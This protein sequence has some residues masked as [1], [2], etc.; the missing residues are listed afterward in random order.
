MSNFR[1]RGFSGK[2]SRFEISG[3]RGKFII[4]F[5]LKIFEEI[6]LANEKVGLQSSYLTKLFGKNPVIWRKVNKERCEFVVKDF[7]ELH[8]FQLAIAITLVNYDQ[9]KMNQIRVLGRITKNLKSFLL[10]EV[11]KSPD[12]ISLHELINIFTVKIKAKNQEKYIRP[13][14]KCA[15][16]EKSA[17]IFK[18]RKVAR[19]LAR[20]V[21]EGFFS[22]NEVR[23]IKIGAYYKK[24]LYYLNISFSG[25]KRSVKKKQLPM[26]LEFCSENTKGL[27][28]GLDDFLSGWKERGA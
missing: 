15:D 18:E 14:K 11:R 21:L 26:C 27:V 23:R 20:E 10:N 25:I 4:N 3:E 9:E 13:E 22:E 17:R 2:D 5:S 19:E 1:L 6:K 8:S 12:Q 7:S 16:Q 24:G 28:R